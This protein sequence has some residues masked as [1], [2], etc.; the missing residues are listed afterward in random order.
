M[1]SER[2]ITRG[3]DPHTSKYLVLRPWKL[4]NFLE[5]IE[6][7]NLN[8]KADTSLQI[9]IRSPTVSWALRFNAM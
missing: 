4:F 2:S 1:Q 9:H 8:H 5:Q 6:Q 3:L 7:I